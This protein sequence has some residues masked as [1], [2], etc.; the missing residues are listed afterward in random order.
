MKFCDKCGV[1]VEGNRQACPLCQ[2]ELRVLDGRSE[3]TFPVI[4]TVYKKHNLFFRI[5]IF[6]SVAACV[7]SV[8]INVMVPTSVW[9]SLFVL[10]GIGCMW[11]TLA[12]VVNKR[13]NIPKC[14]LYH[15]VLLSAFGVLWDVFTGW[16]G[17]SLDYVVPIACITAMIVMSITC[18]VLKL[19]LEEYVIYLIIAAFFGI[20]PIVFL[21]V[22]C[23]N[24]I[25]PSLLC[26]G[27]SILSVAA[28]CIFE[29]ERMIAELKRRLHL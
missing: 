3:E 12:I 6:I 24:V 13:R 4:P 11:V 14:M 21:L 18:R 17:W 7:I 1:T 25:L 8:L 29:G 2:A 15:A 5:L 26:V 16:R 20:V 27:A 19:H 9:W 23:L 22:G 10:A 28:L